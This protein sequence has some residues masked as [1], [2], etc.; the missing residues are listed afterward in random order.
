MINPCQAAPLHLNFAN[1]RSH[2]PLCP[3][4]PKA[5][6]NARANRTF[7]DFGQRKPVQDACPLDHRL[8]SVSLRPARPTEVKRSKREK[9]RSKSEE[10]RVHVR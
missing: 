3:L 6:S 2:I 10:E 4:L 7:R 8:T 5:S 9:E 1:N